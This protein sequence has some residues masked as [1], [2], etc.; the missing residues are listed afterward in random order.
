MPG[1]PGGVLPEPL[2]FDP[3]REDGQYSGHRIG[4]GSE[5]IA[6]A[7]PETGKAVKFRQVAGSARNALLDMLCAIVRHNALFPADAYTVDGLASSGSG[8]GGKLF[9]KISQPLVRPLRDADG[10]TAKPTEGQITSALMKIRQD[11][12]F[13]GT[14]DESATGAEGDSDRVGADGFM[15]VCPDYVVTDFKP[16]ENTFI[17]EKTG[18][19]RFIDPRI[20]RNSP[21]AGIAP[22]AVWQA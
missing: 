5:S 12:V 14:L 15:A 2:G 3:S 11:W 10:Y 1:A 16:G 18:G 17:D 20:L 7:D 8:S 4:S 19:V 9:L 6:F 13:H 22:E 21:T